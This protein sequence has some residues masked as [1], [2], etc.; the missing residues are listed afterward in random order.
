[1]VATLNRGPNADYLT[2]KVKTVFKPI[3]VNYGSIF[4]G[5]FIGIIADVA[6]VLE[7]F[8]LV[9]VS[10][11]LAT[12]HSIDFILGHSLGGLA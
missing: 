1:M 11:V 2:E 5:A 8:E 6:L 10:V 7:S 9:A 4:Q 12:F 3:L